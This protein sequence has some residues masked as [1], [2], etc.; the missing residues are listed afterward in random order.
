MSA[1]SSGCNVSAVHSIVVVGLRAPVATNTA[2][3]ATLTTGT[4]VTPLGI[5]TTLPSPSTADSS[6]AAAITSRATLSGMRELHS[7]AIVRTS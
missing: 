6:S 4:F 7:V 5:T 1:I 3:G 2:D